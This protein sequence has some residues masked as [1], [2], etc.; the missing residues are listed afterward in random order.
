MKPRL[1]FFPPPKRHVRGFTLIEVLVSLAILGI[2]AALA[3]PS[4]SGSIKRQRV[5]SIK[6]DLIASMQTARSEAI[7]RGLNVFLIRSPATGS[8]AL[9]TA[10]EFNC[11]WQLVVD[12]NAN[13]TADATEIT[14]RIQESTVPSRYVVMHTA[15]G[16][17]IRFN[18]WG[19][20]QGTGHG[21][22]IS[23][24]D[25]GVGGA[26]TTTVCISSGGRTKTLEGSASC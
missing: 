14:N 8:C 25:D 1:A 3:A 26:A 16:S 22:V 12:A 13:N 17:S 11:G 7:R 21:F 5:N 2:L 9:A 24:L 15:P 10:P 18:R 19:Q 6:D 4:F 20:A 23:Q